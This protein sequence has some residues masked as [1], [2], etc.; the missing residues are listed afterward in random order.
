MSDTSFRNRLKSL[1]WSESLI[2]KILLLFL[3]IQQNVP[4]TLKPG[5]T[6][7]QGYRLILMDTPNLITI[8]SLR[9]FYHREKIYKRLNLFRV[10]VSNPGSVFELSGVCWV[11]IISSILFFI[12]QLSICQIT[13]L[14]RIPDIFKVLW[15]TSK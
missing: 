3:P 14:M 12:L 13:L 15:L 6:H 11:S 10:T 7:E 9:L 8:R 2:I 5:I 4:E 1:L